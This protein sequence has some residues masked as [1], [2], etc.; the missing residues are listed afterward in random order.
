MNLR[1]LKQMTM[2]LA[3]DHIVKRRRF[4]ERPLTLMEMW[5]RGYQFDDDSAF[6][7]RIVGISGHGRGESCRPAGSHRFHKDRDFDSIS[8]VSVLVSKNQGVKRNFL[9]TKG[10]G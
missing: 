6:R 2:I 4:K 9:L 1:Y 10:E 7:V 5:G 3:A 8:R